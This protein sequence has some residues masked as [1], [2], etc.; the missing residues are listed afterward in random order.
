MLPL[1]D[2]EKLTRKKPEFIFAV[3]AKVMTWCAAVRIISLFLKF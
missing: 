1:K 2:V 3:L